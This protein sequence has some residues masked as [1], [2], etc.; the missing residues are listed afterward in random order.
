MER[1]DSTARRRSICVSWAP[2]H[3]QLR[4]PIC[5]KLDYKYLRKCLDMLLPTSGPQIY[6]IKFWN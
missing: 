3:V 1:A 5:V 6:N 4:D 2:V